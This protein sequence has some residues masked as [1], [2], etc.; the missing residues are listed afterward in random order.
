MAFCPH[1]QKGERSFC[2][3]EYLRIFWIFRKFTCATLVGCDFVRPSANAADTQKKQRHH[4]FGGCLLY[5]VLDPSWF[6]HST[7]PRN[8]DTSSEIRGQRYTFP[9]MTLYLWGTKCPLFLFMCD[10]FF[11]WR[12]AILTNN[13]CERKNVGK[14]NFNRGTVCPP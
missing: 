6:C 12:W 1:Q 10:I 4:I 9:Y 3:V 5:F 14:I 13:T 11:P 7:H 8:A 2:N